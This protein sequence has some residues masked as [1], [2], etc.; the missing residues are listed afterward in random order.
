M[1]TWCACTTLN[2]A[3]LFQLA[4]NR[5]QCTGNHDVGISIIVQHHHHD[6]G[7]RTVC[8]PVRHSDAK[9]LKEARR[10]AARIAENAQQAIDLH[11]E[12]IIY[13]T[14][15]SSERTFFPGKSLRT[16]SHAMMLPKGTAIK[17]VKNEISS[18]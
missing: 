6:D 12:G 13:G 17:Q 2:F 16:M 14:M 3:H 8:Q 9:T 7:N 18:E 15:I 1:P 10:A 4:V 11:H 5:L